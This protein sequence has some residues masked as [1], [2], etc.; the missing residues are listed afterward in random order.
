MGFGDGPHGM[1]CGCMFS[2]AAVGTLGPIGVSSRNTDGT[3]SCEMQDPNPMN[4][5]QP[6]TNSCPIRCCL[7]GCKPGQRGVG[8][9]SSG[10]RVLQR[11]LRQ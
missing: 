1:R 3:L 8:G 2:H 6:G 10:S 11:R 9:S 7:L 5:Q 4:K